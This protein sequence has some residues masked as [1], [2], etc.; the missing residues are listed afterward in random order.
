MS[1]HHA[2]MGMSAMEA[3]LAIAEVH[4]AATRIA[5]IRQQK[6]IRQLQ[7]RGRASFKAQALLHELEKR[8][9]TCIL[10]RDR[11][12]TKLEALGESTENS[13]TAREDGRSG[14]A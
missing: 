9:A 13:S 4:V 1:S 14:I 2:P 6:C 5:V 8:H 10:Y 11:C 12:R 7:A 3:K